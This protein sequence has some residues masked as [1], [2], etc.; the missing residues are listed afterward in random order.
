MLK[1][2]LYVER[3]WNTALGIIAYAEPRTANAV[4][5]RFEEPAGTT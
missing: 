4:T 3:G 2:T 5:L 1:V